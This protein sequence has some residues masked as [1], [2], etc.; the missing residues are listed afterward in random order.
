MMVA[1]P[2]VVQLS[3]VSNVPLRIPINGVEVRGAVREAMLV[4]VVVLLR[5]VLRICRF[6]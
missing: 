6:S 4:L 2:K 3:F 1:A 5:M